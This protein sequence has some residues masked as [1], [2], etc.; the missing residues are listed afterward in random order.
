M[1]SDVSSVAR[2]GDSVSSPPAGKQRSV[3]NCA[4][5]QHTAF[6][7]TLLTY[8]YLPQRVNALLRR[9]QCASESVNL[10]RLSGS[11]PNSITSICC[12]FVVQLSMFFC[13]KIAIKVDV[14]NE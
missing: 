13:K 3:G 1:V 8:Q 5:L 9:A 14:K 6:S 11:S 7:A 12:G 4:N 10:S 2:V